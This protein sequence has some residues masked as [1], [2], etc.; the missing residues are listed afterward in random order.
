MIKFTY[1]GHACFQL[2]D[3]QT[4]ILV[5]PYFTG[6]PAATVAAKD[7]SCNY[8][9]VS[10]AHGDHLG[11]APFIA[12]NCRAEI[13]A[14]PEVLSICQ[15]EA[16]QAVCHPMNVGGE[17]KLPFGKVRMTTAIHSSGVP[18]GVAGGFMIYFG[19]VAVYYAGDTALFADMQYIGEA[20]K[21]DWAILPIGDNYTM[22]IED[23]ATAAKWL[24]VKHVI[25]VHYN[26]WPIIAQDPQ[27]FKELAE[28][29]AM[30]KVHIVAPGESL[31]M[32][33]EALS[34]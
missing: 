26:T 27:L 9:L 4:K 25:P 34:V 11:D 32:R 15:Q 8:I 16:P 1:Y 3:G 18:G 29:Y 28:R 17:L 12:K 31:D 30:T 24:K 21:P 5:D 6:N 19:D 2:A 10:H 22:G 23:A 20:Y 14:I 33:G 7:I 13:V